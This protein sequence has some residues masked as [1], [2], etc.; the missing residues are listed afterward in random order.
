MTQ[1]RERYHFIHNVFANFYKDVLDWLSET[2]YPRFE[3]RVVS[4]YDKAV[5]Y[6]QKRC[7]YGRETN[8]PMLP[9][10]IL[11]PHGDFEP[12][13]ANAGG[14]QYWR[15]P[16]LSPTLAKRLFKPIYKDEHVLVNTSFI[17]IKGEIEL[18]MLLN[19]FY[20]YC[21][22]RMLFINMFGGLNRIIYTKFFSSFI[23]L[24]QSFTEYKY[25]NEY[26]GVEYEL[27]WESAGATEMLVRSTARREMV[28]P[29]NI[30]PQLA[31]QGL[32]D[33]SNRYGGADSIAE[34]KLGA[35]L[36]YEIELPNYLIIES[37]YLAQKIDFEFRYGS[38]FSVYNDYQ[39]PDNR[40]LK[41]YTWDWGLNFDT[42]T[43][44]KLDI[45]DPTEIT[46]TGTFVGDFIFHTRYI[47]EITAGDVDSTS[48]V[49]IDLPEQIV[50]PKILIINSKHGEMNYG[51]HYILINDGW[52]VEI[53]TTETVQLDVGDFIELFVYKQLETI[54]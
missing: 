25:T 53:K 12:A 3:Y 52:T 42:N 16:N 31:L 47:H 22:V 14:A 6:I 34:W 7:Q 39:L 37:D 46:S 43:P 10:L 30:K 44:D 48:N 35:T 38:T 36:N 23:I 32:S 54:E 29:L 8:M 9:A 11:N 17:R 15:Y 20:E 5:E 26:T 19:S 18:I 13:D 24:P 28:L 27:D 1:I 40:I 51:P 41:N 45:L 50:E 4:N 33:A 49:T 21:D 2:L